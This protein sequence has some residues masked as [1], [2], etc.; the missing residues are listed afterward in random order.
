LSG[1]IVDRGDRKPE[2][3]PRLTRRPDSVPGRRT[4]TG[5]FI[6]IESG[7]AVVKIP[8]RGTGGEPAA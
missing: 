6:Q 7:S 3:Q 5:G 4:V 2:F 1:T 8:R